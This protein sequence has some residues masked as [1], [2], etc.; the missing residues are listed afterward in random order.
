MGGD[1]CVL[2]RVLTDSSRFEPFFSV[3]YPFCQLLVSNF[4]SLKRVATS[5]FGEK[6]DLNSRPI[7]PD[8]Y[9]ALPELPTFTLTSADMTAGGQMPT[10]QIAAGENLSPQLSWS[11]FPKE[12]KSFLL[13]CFDPDAPTPSGFWHWLITDIPAE[14]TSLPTG[15][16]SSDLEL[17]GPAFHL[18]NDGGG[19]SYMGAAPPK[20]DRPHRYIFAVHALDTE[21]LELDEDASAAVANFQALFHCLA[22][23]TLEVTYQNK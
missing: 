1:Y 21:T 2:W 17:D 22:R 14:M 6:M 13:T 20:G 23:A 19:W 9:E 3:L 11:G 4:S 15:A 5:T 16:G 8:P 7:A 12:T 10:A 18:R